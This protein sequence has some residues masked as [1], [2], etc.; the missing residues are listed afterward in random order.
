MKYSMNNAQNFEI[1]SWWKREIWIFFWKWYQEKKAIYSY[2][3][4]MYIW[5]FLRK[6]WFKPEDSNWDE[7]YLVFQSLLLNSWY[8]KDWNKELLSKE[9]F[10]IVW[11]KEIQLKFDSEKVKQY[12]EISWDNFDMLEYLQKAYS[13]E[14]YFWFIPW[15]NNSNFVIFAKKVKVEVGFTS[16]LQKVVD[17]STLWIDECLAMIDCKNLPPEIRDLNL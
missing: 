1:I 11:I 15:E 5:P 12:K 9:W 16:W 4:S 6:F 14:Y 2:Y 8:Y 10:E 17:V 7:Q 3:L 13:W